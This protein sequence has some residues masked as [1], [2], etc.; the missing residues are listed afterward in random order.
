MCDVACVTSRHERVHAE[1]CA[2][3][4]RRGSGDGDRQGPEAAQDLAVAAYSLHPL[5]RG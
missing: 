2:G 4:S 5:G 3:A 1:D